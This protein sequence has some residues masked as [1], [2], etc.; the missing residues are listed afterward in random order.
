MHTHTHT[1]I[2]CIHIHTHTHTLQLAYLHRS[3]PRQ[4]ALLQRHAICRGSEGAWERGREGGEEQEQAACI[5][6]F[7]KYTISSIANILGFCIF[8]HSQTIL[9]VWEDQ[10][11]AACMSYEEGDTC[12]SYE[13]EDTCMS[14]EEEDTCMSYEEEDTCMS[15]EEED[16]CMPYEE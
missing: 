15:C 3:V 7:E 8:S 2:L 1:S 4:P 9:S 10:K 14:Y 5:H 11:R 12:M 16:T 13:E 6:S